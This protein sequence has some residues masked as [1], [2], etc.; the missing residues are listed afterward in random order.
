MSSAGSG[1]ALPSASAVKELGQLAPFAP[2]LED[3]V[4]RSQEPLTHFATVVQK[5]FAFPPYSQMTGRASPLG[6]DSHASPEFGCCDG[7]RAVEPELLQAASGIAM[8]S[9]SRSVMDLS[10]ANGNRNRHS[11]RGRPRVRMFRMHLALFRATRMPAPI[12]ISRDAQK[13]ANCSSGRIG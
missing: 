5:P 8:K 1:H 4:V 2:Q 11:V 9:H 7:Q 13:A 3:G 10:P 12:R 6:L